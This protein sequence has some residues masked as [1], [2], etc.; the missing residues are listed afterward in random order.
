MT[1]RDNRSLSILPKISDSSFNDLHGEST[2]CL[3]ANGAY[4]AAIVHCYTTTNCLSTY[5]QTDCSLETFHLLILQS[6]CYWTRCLIIVSQIVDLCAHNSYS[7]NYYF[8][9]N[10]AKQCYSLV[11][12]SSP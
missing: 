9:I 3:V 2:H 5:L 10:L 11:L 12:Q 1:A 6:S 7:A 4:L 8:A